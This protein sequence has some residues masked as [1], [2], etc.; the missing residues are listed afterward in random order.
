MAAEDGGAEVVEDE[1]E[2]ED[3]F[4][5]DESEAGSE[6]RDEDAKGERGN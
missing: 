6:E 3:G 2:R 5:G 4:G 1:R